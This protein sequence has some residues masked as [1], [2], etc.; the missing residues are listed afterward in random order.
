MGQDLVLGH[1]DAL[2]QR[3]AA[4]GLALA[5]VV[6]VLQQ[7]DAGAAGGEHGDD[8][9]ALGAVLDRR[10][11]QHVGV[12]RA[13][14]EA[15]ASGELAP[16]GHAG[17][18]G[19]LVERVEGVAPEPALRRRVAQ[20]GLPL[21]RAAEQAYRGQLQVMEGEHMRH[22]AVCPCQLA[23]DGQRLGPAR[24]ETAVF[25]RNA[26]LQE[27]ARAQ[28][29]ALGLRRAPGEVARGGGFGEA[30]GQ[31]CGDGGGGSAVPVFGSRVWASLRLMGDGSFASVPARL[32]RSGGEGGGAKGVAGGAAQA[33]TVAR[34]SA[35]VSPMRPKRLSWVRRMLRE[36]PSCFAVRTW[37][38]RQYS[39]AVVNSSCSMRS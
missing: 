7:G 13:G 14:A 24:A 26:Q 36:M 17:G 25:A 2:E 8:E 22:R 37:F 28:Q 11:Q 21:F 4:V 12:E 5:H 18:D 3:A 39:K 31:A 15:L 32:A 23:Y 20:P 30:C 19:A 33:S 34:A 29:V 38:S 1:R 35:A 16:A 27:T 6:P 10:G 9:L